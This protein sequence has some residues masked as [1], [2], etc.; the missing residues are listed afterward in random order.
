MTTYFYFLVKCLIIFYVLYRIWNL[1]FNEGFYGLWNRLFSVQPANDSS[2]NENK[3]VVSETDSII[4]KTSAVYIPEPEVLSPTRS[5]KLE[6]SDNSDE[7]SEDDIEYKT[8]TA[9]HS[10]L[11]DEEIM[12][13]NREA[14]ADDPDFTAGLTFEN[15]SN[16]AAILISKSET[17]DYEKVADAARTLYNLRNTDMFEFFTTQISNVEVI[18]NMFK[19][20]LDD[21]GQPLPERSPQKARKELDNFDIGKYV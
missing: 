21:S 8:E 15:L 13:L 1:L 19:E 14:A 11:D 2:V 12:E 9:R 3:S 16:A 4:G 10:V 5:Q 17:A 18:E 7:L 20:Y 6:A